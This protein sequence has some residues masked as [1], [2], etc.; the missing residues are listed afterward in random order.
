M[1]DD[2][3][4]LRAGRLGFDVYLLADSRNVGYSYQ[5]VRPPIEF[6]GSL[7]ISY[8]DGADMVI[9]KPLGEGNLRA[10][11]FAGIAREKTATGDPGNFLSLNGSYLTGGHIEYQTQNWMY[12]VGYTELKFK[13]GYPPLKPLLNNLRSPD[14]NAFLPVAAVLADGLEI[15]NKKF[16]YF[17]AGIAYDQGPL[18][19]QLMVNRLSSGSLL[20]PANRAAY[21][22]VGYRINQWTPYVTYSASRP[23]GNKTPA[24][25]SSGI[26]PAVD[27]LA[28]GYNDATMSQFSNQD[29][30]SIGVRYDLTEKSNLKFQVD[31]INTKQY[32]LIRNNQANWNGK[33][34]LV[35]LAF[36]YIF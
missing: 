5:W 14:L 19:A 16:R 9:S 28:A 17:S 2:E 31:Q 11:F 34:R 23:S 24:G 36:N 33:A 4:Q 8:F 29:T 20:F 32:L 26:S 15:E 3:I 12:R 6:F 30:L 7:I 27:I 1:P 10:K 22:T 18:Q 13:N 35:T 25:L 21:L